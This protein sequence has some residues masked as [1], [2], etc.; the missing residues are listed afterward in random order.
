[1][2]EFIKLLPPSRITGRIPGAFTEDDEDPYNDPR[3]WDN[4]P[5]T[6]TFPRFP[7]PPG[8]PGVQGGKSSILHI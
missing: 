3:D 4:L 5:V 6:F 8:P 7:C 2:G 1:M